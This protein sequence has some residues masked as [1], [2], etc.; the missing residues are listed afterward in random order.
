MSFVLITLILPVLQ[1]S[2]YMLTYKVFVI[3]FILRLFVA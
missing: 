1:Q 3:Y 2:V